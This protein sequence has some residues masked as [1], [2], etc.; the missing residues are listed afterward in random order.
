MEHGFDPRPDRPDAASALRE[1]AI[2][3]NVPYLRFL[4]DRGF[5][6]QTL[7]VES[8][9]IFL[10]AALEPLP[11][12]ALMLDMLLAEGLD[13]N[14]LDFCGQ[15]PLLQ[16]VKRQMNYDPTVGAVGLLLSRGANPIF[17][18]TKG[19]YPLMLYF[20]GD[21]EKILEAISNAIEARGIPFADVETQLL[22]AMEQAVYRKSDEA[23]RI[24]RRLYWRRRYPVDG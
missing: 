12:A 8:N 23:L 16:S 3:A 1:A 20:S 11:E 14:A 9:L 2:E 18:C 17:R 21:A 15:T 22:Q 6:P 19:E 13:I 5:D 7:G 4:L 10:A 24:L